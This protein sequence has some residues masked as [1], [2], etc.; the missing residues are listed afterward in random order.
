MANLAEYAKAVLMDLGLPEDEAEQQIEDIGGLDDEDELDCDECDG[1][2]T[3]IHN[4]GKCGGCDVCGCDKEYEETCPKCNGT[5]E[6]PN[7]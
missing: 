6:Y 5:G 4:V 1:E 7:E 2:G 3:T